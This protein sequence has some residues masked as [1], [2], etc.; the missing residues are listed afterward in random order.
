MLIICNWMM[1]GMCSSGAVSTL[2]FVW[3]FSCIMFHSLIHAYMCSRVYC[4]CSW[5]WREREHKRTQTR[6]NF[7]LQGLYFRF[8]QKPV[9][10]LVLAK[11]LMNRYQ[12]TGIIYIHIGMNEWVKHYTWEFLHKHS[13]FTAP[14]EHMP[15]I[16][17]LHIMSIEPANKAAEH[18]IS[19]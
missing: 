6:K 2:C 9:Q 5:A 14:D 10:Q 12:I 18:L 15:Y 8:S 13:V 7:I 1:Y 4:V 17:Q 16:I 11:L 19:S 3:K